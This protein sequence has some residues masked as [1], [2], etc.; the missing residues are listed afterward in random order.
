MDGYPMLTVCSIC[1]G[2]IDEELGEGTCTCEDGD[3]YE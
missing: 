2:W 1:H 3:D